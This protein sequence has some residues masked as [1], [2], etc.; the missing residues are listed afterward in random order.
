M[1]SV[2]GLVKRFGETIA[3]DGVSFDVARGEVL[4][5]LGPNGAGKTTTMRIL[6]T[7]LGADA[8]TATLAGFDVARQPLE[9]R[10]NLGYLPESAP[11]YEDMG[12]V[13]YLLYVAGMRGFRGGEGRARVA[14]VVDVCGLGPAVG[15]MIGQLSKGF[16]QR[17]GLAQAMIHEPDILIL[18]EP[19]SGLDPNQIVE[20]RSLI[21]EIGREKTVVLSTHI[22]PE[23]S[24]TCGRVIIIAGGKLVGS[25][26]PD[27]LAGQA[28]GGVGVQI[29][30]R[31]KG[32][33]IEGGLLGLAGVESVDFTGPE[34]DGLRFRVEGREGSETTRLAEA[35]SGLAALRGWPLRELRP[36][37]AS[38]EDV[39][40][41]L[42][43]REEGQE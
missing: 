38:L 3:V 39:F 30:V 28:A 29:V 13:D 26:T 14:R 21:K 4:G 8:G 32:E 40:R 41:T 17:V 5:F 24:A 42:T 23:V 33:D 16:R 2:R 9:V 22:L 35:V 15:K 12:T 36:I 7:F 18:D 11:L 6:T 31:G 19:T 10:R 20:I 43:T 1:I 27:E 34:G 37:S 25:G